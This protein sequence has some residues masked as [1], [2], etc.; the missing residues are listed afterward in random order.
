M[1]SM[2]VLDAASISMTSMGAPETKSRQEGQAPHASAPMRAEQH[3]ALARSRAVVVFPRPR[4]PV[5]RYAWATRPET[6]AFLSVRV[7]GS[8]PTTASKAKG[9]HFRARTR[10][11]MDL[12]SARSARP[13]SGEGGPTASQVRHALVRPTVGREGA[14]T[15]NI[16][17]VHPQSSRPYRER[18]TKPAPVRYSHGTRE[19]RLTAAPFRAW[20]GSTH[21]VAWGPTLNAVPYGSFDT[22][23]PREGIQ[24]R[25][26]GL[27]VTGHRYLP[28]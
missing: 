6:S 24:P 16:M 10:Y 22:S 14:P 1:S 8:W 18:R 20:R 17:T 12:P 27:R 9:R 13:S 3:R 21:P 25:C 7:I 23:G 19:G 2:P 4:G 28:I 5:K 26:S 15:A 11:V